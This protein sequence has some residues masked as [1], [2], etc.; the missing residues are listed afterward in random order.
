MKIITEKLKIGD[1]IKAYDYDTEK[2]IKVKI[3]DIY[4]QYVILEGIE[5][6]MEGDTFT[7][8]LKNLE[9]SKLYKF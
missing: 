4:R 6:N 2:W 7:E 8:T 3:L 1:T 5:G 9:D